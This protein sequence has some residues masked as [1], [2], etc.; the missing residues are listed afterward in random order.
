[1]ASPGFGVKGDTK[2]REDNLTVIHKKYEI[3][4]I[5]GDKAIG[6]HIFIGYRQPH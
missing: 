1:V 3:D 2:Q 6:L 5:N 4:A